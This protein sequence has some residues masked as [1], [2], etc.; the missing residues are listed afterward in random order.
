MPAVDVLHIIRTNVHGYTF[1]LPFDSLSSHFVQ[2]RG[3]SI[4]D[5]AFL[6]YWRSYI[7]QSSRTTLTQKQYRFL[8]FHL[9]KE[10]HICVYIHMTYA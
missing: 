4:L 9:H 10:F 5:D 7:M 6:G 1:F 2:F 3:D 8:Y